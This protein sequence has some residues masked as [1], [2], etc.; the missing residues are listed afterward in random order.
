[1][2]RRKIGLLPAPADPGL[3]SLRGGAGPLS[4]A[5][6][7]LPSTA[8]IHVRGVGHAVDDEHVALV[9]PAYSMQQSPAEK[10]GVRVHAPQ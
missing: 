4:A 8:A 5:V 2:Q 1:M 6:T 10:L 3:V 7:S 9:A